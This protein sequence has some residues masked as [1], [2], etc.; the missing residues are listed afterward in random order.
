MNWDIY[1]T[2]LNEITLI[3]LHCTVECC[4]SHASFSTE[5]IT[6]RTCRCYG[7]KPTL[8][9]KA[10][11]KKMREKKNETGFKRNMPLILQPPVNPLE[12]RHK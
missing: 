5:K 8:S 11:N 3:P 1:R 10:T 4:I 6:S 7:V 9:T 2:R 12:R